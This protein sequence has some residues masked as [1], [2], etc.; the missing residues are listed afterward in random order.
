MGDEAVA[1]NA[2]SP[3]MKLQRALATGETTPSSIAEEYLARTNANASH[4]TYLWLDEGWVLRQAADLERRYAGKEKPPLYGIPVSLKDCFDLEGAPTSAGT[5]F[6]ADRLGPAARDSVV[7]ERL[8][9]AGM[10]IMGKTHLHALAYGITGENPDYGDCLQPRDAKLLTGG[11]SSGAVASV[12]EGSAVIGIGTDTGGS[13]RVPAALC[14][15][16][17]YRI[18]HRVAYE[19]GRWSISDEGLWAGGVHL[20]QSFDTVGVFAHDVRDAASAVGTLFGIG[21][22]EVNIPLRFGCVTGEFLADCDPEV[23]DGAAL[24]RARLT[25][26]GGVMEEFEPQGWEQASGIFS[27]I[28]AHEAA[29]LHRGHYDAFEP[30]IAER[31]YGGAESTEEQ[32]AELRARMSDFSERLVAFFQRVDFLLLP[33]APIRRLYAGEDHGGTRPRILRYTT[34]FSLAGLPIL[35]L[36]GEMVGGARGTGVQIAAKPGEDGKLLGLAEA[37]GSAIAS[38]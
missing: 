21:A 6:Y 25:T 37:V 30:S 2:D 29:A 8:K 19:P 11:S 35:T 7:A 4:N 28:Q 12:Q 16:V 36:P 34:P 9:A 13:V 18:S 10:L 20:A 22:P 17:G 3:L 23:L 14:G 31:L 24:W 15:L 27:A 1:G 32:V 38:A 5:R 26:A 33:C